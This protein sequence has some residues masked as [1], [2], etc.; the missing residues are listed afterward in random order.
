MKTINTGFCHICAGCKVCKNSEKPENN[1]LIDCTDKD[2]VTGHKTVPK[3][4]DG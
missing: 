3:E 2:G 1:P 4:G